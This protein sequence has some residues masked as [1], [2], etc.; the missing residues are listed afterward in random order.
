MDGSQEQVLKPSD[1]RHELR[2]PL[3]QIIGYSE[4]LLEDIGDDGDAEL[5]SEI[6][7]I[8]DSAYDLV[9]AVQALVPNGDGIGSPDSLGRIR[10]G[11]S[12]RANRLSQAAHSLAAREEPILRPFAQHIE[13]AAR[14]LADFTSGATL[15]R[16][17]ENTG[18][19]SE[20]H[21]A[22]SGAR[23]LVADD[24]ERNRE[25]LARQLERQG[26]SVT[27]VGNGVDALRLLRER[28]YDL[29]LLDVLMPEM[30]GFSAL[31]AI[32]T[33]PELREIPVIMI[34]ASDEYSSVIRCIESGAED[35]LPKPFD[36]V[37]LRAR[38]KASLEKKALRDE[39]KRKTEELERA[40][41]NLQRMQDQLVTQEKLASLGSLAAGIAHE[42]KNP[43]NFITNFAKLSG[44]LIPELQSSIEQADRVE[45]GEIL[46]DLAANLQR[47]Q[48]HGA[49]ADRIVRGMLGHA[50]QSSGER[51]L[52]DINTLV[53][54]SVNL[55]YHGV[56]SHDIRFNVAIEYRLDPQV[57]KANVFPQDLNRVFLN[58][59]TNAFHALQ[60]EARTA[61][62]DFE[63][64]FIVVSRQF[65]DNVEIRFCDNGPGI[66]A[67]L[68]RKIFEPFFTTK[69][70]GMGTGLG[71]SISHDVV[72][73]EH[74]GELLVE[75]EPGI[76]TE[77]I[78]RI[79]RMLTA[80]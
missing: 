40:Y 77:F 56:R 50:R 54:E 59:A 25:I 52:T 20:E 60:D 32:K 68:Q 2:T 49:R 75:S 46:K 64:S 45:A 42:I 58:I 35:Y 6:D 16:K 11:L 63:P 18:S 39:Q 41:V 7:A 14:N 36:P 51:E 28:S 80:Q 3:N 67:D 21:A 15:N 8:H 9:G 17:A 29:A 24:S 34:S 10:K 70:A 73:K 43:L 61:R 79:P 22:S 69:P 4:M 55:A 38:L 1:L 48:D 57:G 27:C 65:G 71:L 12:D 23:L 66:S 13:S 37:L 47:I 31:E 5:R 53:V 26:Y 72:V 33:D 19:V 76:S 62:R 74:H 44:E 78:V 30:D